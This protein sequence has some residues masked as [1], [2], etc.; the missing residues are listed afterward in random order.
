MKKML[1]AAFALCLTLPVLADEQKDQ[2]YM[3][4]CKTYAKEDGIAADELADYLEGCV[5]DLKE[6]AESSKD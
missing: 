1:L 3:D 5:K 2:E 6:S 4:L